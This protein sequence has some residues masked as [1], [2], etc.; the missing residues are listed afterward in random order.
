MKQIFLSN[1]SNLSLQVAQTRL[2][3]RSQRPDIEA[4]NDP[5]HLRLVDEVGIIN[6]TILLLDQKI[7]E[8]EA[9]RL[10]LVSNKARLEND[11]RVKG[12][13]LAIDQQKCMTLRWARRVNFH[14]FKIWLRQFGKVGF[15]T[16]L[17]QK[18]WFLMMALFQ[19]M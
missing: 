7:T 16:F 13:S 3:K 17:E 2:K 1:A 9:A 11:I 6:D 19:K 15:C 12:N 18:V 14:P 5:P 8:A 4:C 10:D